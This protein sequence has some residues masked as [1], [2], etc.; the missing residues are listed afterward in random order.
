MLYDRRMPDRAA[1]TPPARRRPVL[2]R[3]PQRRAAAR[4]RSGRRPGP[5]AGR[6]RHRQDPGADRA[7]R[8]YPRHPPR[9][10]VRI[11][12]GH[13]HQ[14]GGARDAPAPRGDDRQRRRRP[15]ARHVS[16]DRRAHP[17]PPCRGR[18]AQ[19]ELYH[20]RHRR[21]DSPAEADP[22]GRGHR[23]AALAG[24][25]AAGGHPALEGSRPRPRQAFARRCRQFCRRPRGRHSTGVIRNGSRPSTPSISAICCCTI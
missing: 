17:A 9:F 7:A 23:R 24:A 2:S 16:C 12:G 15:L 13:L 18:R 3:R 10:S 11:A 6:R 21:P 25:R 22:A 19:I 1:L 8:P 14:Q 5:G 20:P 4:G